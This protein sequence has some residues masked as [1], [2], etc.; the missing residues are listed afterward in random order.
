M[1]VKRYVTKRRF[2]KLKD[3]IK[4]AVLIIQKCWK[5]YK[6]KMYNKIQNKKNEMKL[7]RTHYLEE[8]FNNP[9]YFKILINVQ[10]KFKGL[11]L[12][13]KKATDTRRL[14]ITMSNL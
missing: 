2:Q 3:S 13:L 11:Y 6:V 14:I 12:V 8:W 1:T 5:L 4:K 7:L 9:K 10:K